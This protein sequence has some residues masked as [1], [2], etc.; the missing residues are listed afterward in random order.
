MNT[1]ATEPETVLRD[2][3][4]GGP[5]NSRDI[6][7]AMA[8]RQFTR[9]QTRCAREK[10]RVVIQRAGSGVD[11]HSLWSLPQDG[12][13]GDSAKTAAHAQG[14]STALAPAAAFVPTAVESRAPRGIRFGSRDVAALQG[15][16]LRTY[17]RQVGVSQRDCAGLTEDRLRQNV[18]IVI[19][20]TFEL[21][22]E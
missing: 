6:L 22:T 18:R 1:S 15:D 13:P 8:E 4:A 2:L 16:E 9:K 12:E 11:M 10:L 7:A 14:N 19:A 20:N 21:L 3:L 5:R 17:A